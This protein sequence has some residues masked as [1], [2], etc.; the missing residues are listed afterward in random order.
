MFVEDDKFLMIATFWVAV[1]LL[2]G[3]W[4]KS[5]AEDHGAPGWLGFL[6]VFAISFFMSP[7]FGLISVFVLVPIVS[8]A[9]KRS[10]RGPRPT[11]KLRYTD[12]VSYQRPA[13]RK[14]E[15][16]AAQT[17]DREGR[18]TCPACGERTN[19]QRRSCMACGVDMR[20]L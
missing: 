20:Y 10:Y 19:A 17:P 5:K 13:T 9:Y 15:P 16:I 1:A 11:G 2:F 7:L 12:T 6:V 8:A 3:W 14:T 18:V 4:G